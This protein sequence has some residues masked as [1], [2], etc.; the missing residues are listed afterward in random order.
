VK[1][2]APMQYCVR[3]K[4]G[5]IG[6]FESITLEIDLLPTSADLPLGYK[7]KDKFLVQTIKLLQAELDLPL[8]YLL[9]GHLVPS[10]FYPAGGAAVNSA[11]SRCNIAGVARGVERE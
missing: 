3:P 1:T 5:T 9:P 6:R 10:T 4:S 2:T 11:R 8:D 7:C